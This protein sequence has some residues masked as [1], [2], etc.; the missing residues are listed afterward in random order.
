MK[1][2]TYVGRTDKTTFFVAMRFRYVLIDADDEQE[3]ME[4]SREKFHELFADLRERLGGFLLI[5]I[6]T[7]R[8]ATDEEIELWNAHCANLNRELERKDLQ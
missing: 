5:E 3:A 6:Q 4:E 7:C 8:P 2:F 1:L